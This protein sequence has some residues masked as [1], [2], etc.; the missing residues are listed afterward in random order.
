[1]NAPNTW[2]ADQRDE[3]EPGGRR[4]ED[5]TGPSSLSG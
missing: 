3:Q 2:E 4:P 5:D 1:M